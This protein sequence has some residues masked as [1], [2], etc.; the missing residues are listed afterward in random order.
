M[1]H[2]RATRSVRDPR[3]VPQIVC[4]ETEWQRADHTYARHLGGGVVVW[5]EIP[6]DRFAEHTGWL[7]WHRKD[8]DHHV[9][10]S[11]AKDVHLKAEVNAGRWIVR[12]PCGGAQRASKVDRRFFCVDC[13]NE[14][15]SGQWV[16]VEW[17]REIEA[18]E[19]LL[20]Q[21]P[22]RE[23]ASWVP[24]ESVDDLRSQNAEHLT[25]IVA[26]PLEY[27]AASMGLIESEG[28]PPCIVCQRPMEHLGES[29]EHVAVPDDAGVHIPPDLRVVAKR[30]DEYVCRRCQMGAHVVRPA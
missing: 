13:L 28:V 22:D 3:A 21:R 14:W 16:R 6:P 10:D 15:V 7:H 18:I 8:V 20:S 25:E 27:R 24:G 4:A 23:T 30:F 2:L 29:L 1:P 19:E 11:T 12:C 26:A 17:P 9:P 5:K